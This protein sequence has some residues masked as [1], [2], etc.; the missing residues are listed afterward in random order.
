MWCVFSILCPLNKKS[1]GVVT[2]QT[3]GASPAQ[4]LRPNNPSGTIEFHCQEAKK[5]KSWLP[6]QSNRRGLLCF[7]PLKA[8]NRCT[9]ELDAVVFATMQQWKRTTTI[10]L[11]DCSL[12]CRVATEIQIHQTTLKLLLLMHPVNCRGFF[13]ALNLLPSRVNTIKVQ[14]ELMNL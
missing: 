4:G 10:I 5:K 2:A 3:L 14:C 6:A 12:K 13:P 7:T 11:L 9:S 8:E 1:T